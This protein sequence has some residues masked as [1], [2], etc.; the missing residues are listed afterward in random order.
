MCCE[1]TF[2]I[3]LTLHYTTKLTK[4]KTAEHNSLSVLLVQLDFGTAVSQVDTVTMSHGPMGPVDR[5]EAGGRTCEMNRELHW[6]LLNEWP[7][8]AAP[9]A[10][11]Q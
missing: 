3:D 6:S 11:G 10:C 5:V 9:M 7:V 1:Q 8:L 2:Y 4:A